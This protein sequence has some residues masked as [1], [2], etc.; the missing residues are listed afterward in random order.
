MPMRLFF[1]LA[2]AAARLPDELGAGENNV[3]LS[4]RRDRR[5]RRGLF[6]AQRYS[7]VLRGAGRRKQI[8]ISETIIQIAI[9][10]AA[11]DAIAATMPAGLGGYEPQI[12]ENGERLIWL[13]GRCLA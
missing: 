10:Q 3:F 8:T 7:A 1:V 6:A 9:S 12:N 13:K 11:L 4:R 2:C 5:G